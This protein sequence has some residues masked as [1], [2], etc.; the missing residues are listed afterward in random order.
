MGFGMPVGRWLRGELRE[1]CAALLDPARIR[2]QGLLDADMVTR[3]WNEHAQGKANR[4]HEVW[5]LVMLQSWLE[6]HGSE[7]GEKHP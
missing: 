6:T 1:W 7:R 5:A 3:I 2:A 4:Q